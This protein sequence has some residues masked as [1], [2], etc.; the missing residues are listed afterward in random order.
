MTSLTIPSNTIQNMTLDYV[1]DVIEDLKEGKQQVDKTTLT[2]LIKRRNTLVSQLSSIDLSTYAVED[3]SSSVG[4]NS[5]GGSGGGTPFQVIEWDPITLGAPTTKVFTPDANSV[6]TSTSLYSTE[7][8]ANSIEF[9][10]GFII[11]YATAYTTISSTISGSFNLNSISTKYAPTLILFTDHVLDGPSIFTAITGQGFVGSKMQILNVGAIGGSDVV[12][13]IYTN[14]Q[15]TLTAVKSTDTLN[16]GIDFNSTGILIHAD[17]PVQF[18]VDFDTYPIMTIV[19]LNDF[20]LAQAGQ[21]SNVE[22]VGFVNTLEGIPRNETPIPEEA[23]DGDKLIVITN[24]GTLLGQVV[25]IGDECELYNDKTEFLLNRPF[26]TE[27]ATSLEGDGT[28]AQ[29]LTQVQTVVDNPSAILLDKAVSIVNYTHLTVGL[30]MP[31]ILVSKDVR[32]G[33]IT[34]NNR[35]HANRTVIF[36]SDVGFYFKDL[37]PSIFSENE[38]PIYKESISEGLPPFSTTTYEV[39]FSGD[40]GGTLRKV[41]ETTSENISDL[42]PSDPIIILSD[43]NENDVVSLDEQGE[44]PIVIRV[45]LTNKRRGY[46]FR[47]ICDYP[48]TIE[49][50]EVLANIPYDFYQDA[51]YFLSYA[52]ITRGYVDFNVTVYDLSEDTLISMSPEFRVPDNVNLGGH[53]YGD[54]LYKEFLLEM[55]PAPLEPIGEGFTFYYLEDVVSII[56]ENPENSLVDLSSAAS[57]GTSL[58]G[59]LR[60]SWGNPGQTLNLTAGN[61]VKIDTRVSAAGGRGSVTWD[62]A[63]VQPVLDGVVDGFYTVTQTDIDN[64]YLDITFTASALYPEQFIEFTTSF[65]YEGENVPATLERVANVFVSGVDPVYSSG[66]YIEIVTNTDYN[67]PN[68]SEAYPTITGKGYGDILSGETTFDFELGG[69]L[70][71]DAKVVVEAFVSDTPNSGFGSS[72]ILAPTS[73]LN[74]H[75]I[76][77]TDIDNGQTPTFTMT[78]ETPGATPYFVKLISY[79]VDVTSGDPVT[80][81]YWTYVVIHPL[82]DEVVITGDTLINGNV[83]LLGSVSYDLPPEAVAGDILSIDSYNQSAT[84]GPIPGLPYLET[85][86]QWRIDI[87]VLNA[88]YYYPFN[89]GNYAKIINTRVI[90]ENITGIPIKGKLGTMTVDVTF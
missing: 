27:L 64:Y 24:D 73:N 15:G 60:Y 66:P 13:V 7:N 87:G 14:S 59:T 34:I 31:D 67:A 9:M 82:I 25:K 84:A 65:Q 57:S 22:A 16:L 35:T 19:T 80:E 71:L 88:D 4:G 74:D 47:I 1:L 33:K 6:V 52:D 42:T 29:A 5:S 51:Y 78:F 3:V 48:G 36:R 28:L 53:I 43:T 10:P 50:T 12:S 37:G 63:L 20:I 39:D 86:E 26:D 55:P 54:A 45:P 40:N 79:L 44:G 17:V 81:K 11:N 68:T 75:I 85:M 90:R 77:Q 70:I 2:N 61:V 49:Y 23:N 58:A 18:N 62:S 72:S 8:P 83:T 38:S 32:S 30:Q 89:F 69:E 46:Y 21:P 56:T 76:T 41:S